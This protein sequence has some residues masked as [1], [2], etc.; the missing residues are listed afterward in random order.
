MR[1]LALVLGVTDLLSLLSAIE[2][3]QHHLLTQLLLLDRFALQ[4]LVLL[5]LLVEQNRNVVKLHKGKINLWA[6]AWS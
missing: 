1:H 6:L 4:L 5:E 2:H 3:D